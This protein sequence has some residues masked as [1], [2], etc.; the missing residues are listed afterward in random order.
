[1]IY[2]WS[3]PSH[4]WPGK[5]SNPTLCH[6]CESRNPEKK[7]RL[8]DSRLRGNDTLNNM[9]NKER[10][11]YI[12]ILVSQKNG[13]LYIGVTNNLAERV[14]Q[15]KEKLTKGFTSKYD[16]DKLVYYEI[17]GEIG[18]AIYREKCLK[19]WKREWKMKLIEDFN[20]SW[21]DLYEKL[22]K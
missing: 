10:Q 16:V 18:M 20:P 6:S 11:Y 4:K 22:L 21:K 13:T 1:L 5:K 12:Y 19:R 9:Y 15:H 17:Y 14:K 2:R 7:K 8:S 3:L